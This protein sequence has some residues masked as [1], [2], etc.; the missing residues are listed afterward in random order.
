MLQ[1]PMT[2]RLNVYNV[3]QSCLFELTWDRGKRLTANLSFPTQ[4]IDHYS[5]WRAAYL[6]YYQ[7]ALRGRVKAIGHLHNLEAD[8]HSQLVQAEAKLLFE[9]HRWLGHGNLFEMQKEL[10]QAKPDSPRAAGHNLSATPIELFLTCEPMAVAR[11]PWETWDLGCHIQIVR[12][13]PTLRSAPPL[14]LSPRRGKRTRVLAILGDDTGL[15]FEA[16]R[17]ALNTH[18]AWLDIHYVGWQPKENPHT[19]R[20]RICQTIA[21]SQGWDILFFAGHS[22]EAAL[23]DGQI[24][25][26]PNITI[27]VRDLAPYLQQA[28]R[29]GLQFALFNSCSG[30][31]IAHGL[32]S[33]GLS[34]VAI[35]REPIH[36]QV[37]QVFLVQFL[38][39]LAQGQDVQGALKTT[40]QWLKQAQRL[41]YPSADLVPSLF[42][43]PQSVPY[44][45]RPRGW[46]SIWQRWRPTWTEA[47]A[48]GALTLL[49]LL[50]GVQDW[51]MD[52]RVF[53]QAVYRTITNQD[54]A[55]AGPPILLVQIDQET[56]TRSGITEYKPISRALLAA[57]ITQLTAL[58]A[59]VIG[60][61]YLL[62]LAQPDHDPSLHLVVQ[63]AVEHHQ[64]WPVFITV[65]TSGGA[66]AGVHPQVATPAWVL[67]GDAWVPLWHVLPRRTAAHGRPAF[68][69]QMVVA[70]WL[71]QT[72]LGGHSAVPQP[73]RAE[74]SL[75]AAVQNYLASV[76]RRGEASH[77]SPA[78]GLFSPRAQL[79]PL[80]ATSYW[81]NQRWLQPLLDFSIPPE[82]V[83]ATIPAWQLLES[84]GTISPRLETDT[85]ADVI[86]IV[87][88]GGYLQ[89]GVVADGDDNLPLPPAIDYW[90][91]RSGQ[92]ANHFTGGEAHAYMA[93]HFLVNRLVV[94]IPDFWMVLALALAGKALVFY[95]SDRPHR[96]LM[97]Y[98]VAATTGYGLFS[99][100]LYISGAILLPWLLPS[101]VLWLYGVSILRGEN[102]G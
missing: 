95:W 86:V 74:P 94:P 55:Q 75:D 39:H 101:L 90:Y 65:E 2:F 45:L 63:Q 16:E 64:V 61:D 50:P 83:Y 36:N 78:A 49:S 102:D 35:M 80:T 91:G 100:Q 46:Q 88:A 11:L 38:Q 82:Q 59:R 98:L 77:P 25:I 7:Q 12:S 84:P 71:S 89:A 21:H 18:R 79:H 9:F 87:A 97:I 31:D 66:W 52:Q 1:S 3:G 85:L 33:L 99:L 30:L 34:Q 24:A 14:E 68:S 40:C 6:S 17:A 26:A 96:R 70:H 15:N 58:E 73:G 76:Q 53:A 22:N 37:A 57:I 29:R 32:I 20:E 81:L 56:F 27:F 13:P 60:L 44:R 23:L 69:Y 19:L 48:V 42:R 28:Q 43:H 54:L 47:L 51:L 41:H 10:L 67:Q 4:L 72:A 92:R 93:H 5:A 8:W 62:D